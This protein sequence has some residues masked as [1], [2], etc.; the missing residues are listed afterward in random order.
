MSTESTNAP[1]IVSPSDDPEGFKALIGARVREAREE[2]GW[3]QRE[4]A[5]RAGLSCMA[6]S[7][8][9]RGKVPPTSLNLARIAEATGQE[10]GWFFGEGWPR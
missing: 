2:L 10:P 3:S 4:L 1:R 7:Y 5:R 8:I 9:E 6:L